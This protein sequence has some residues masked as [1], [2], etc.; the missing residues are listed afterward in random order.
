[1]LTVACR[2]HLVVEAGG[3]SVSLWNRV[4]LCKSFFFFSSAN[5][6]I[7]MVHSEL[8]NTSNPLSCSHQIVHFL[9]NL[10][11]QTTSVSAAFMRT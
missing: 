7:N 6:K 5:L 1:M 2:N 9:K 8:G 10:R 11:C 4:G 3:E